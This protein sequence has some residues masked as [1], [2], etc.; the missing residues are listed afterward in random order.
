[1]HHGGC[2]RGEGEVGLEVAG[3]KGIIVHKGIQIKGRALV[4][5]HLVLQGHPVG[6]IERVS[7]ELRV[8]FQVEVEA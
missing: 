2:G 5:G 7:I 1:M 4:V 8:G 3:A 6:V